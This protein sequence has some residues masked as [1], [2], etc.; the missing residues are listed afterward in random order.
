MLEVHQVP[1]TL[2]TL[3]DNNNN[4]SAPMAGGLLGGFPPMLSLSNPAL[5]LQLLQAR[6]ASGGQWISLL[7]LL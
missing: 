7:L 5:Q 4:N 1:M 2:S 3:S 6:L